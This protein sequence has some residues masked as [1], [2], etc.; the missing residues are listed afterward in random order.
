MKTPK[1]WDE[2]A[3]QL[4]TVVADAVTSAFVAVA[5]AGDSIRD[6][7]VV[8]LAEEAG[9]AD[10]SG[11]QA[12]AFDVQALW[13]GKDLDPKASRSG[14]ALNNVVTGMRGAQS[15]IVMFGMMARFLPAGVG[16]ILMMNPVTVGLGVAF[17]G[18]Q[19]LDA[20]K[21]RITQR[22]QAA[23]VSVRQFVDDVQFEVGNASPT[24]FVACSARSGTSSPS[25]SPS[26]SAPT[27]TPDGKRPRR[28]SAPN[29]RRRSAE[30]RSRAP[31]R[32]SA[33]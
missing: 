2:L 22:R 15:G 31:S 29:R 12:V 17:G 25:G 4:Q 13:S 5:E 23:R 32:P 10:G 11:A 28:P 20:H 27:P 9:G 1:E 24:R 16:A 3:R 21:R 6:D 30:R 19:L 18:M 14:R 8:L 33:P 7:V 26:C